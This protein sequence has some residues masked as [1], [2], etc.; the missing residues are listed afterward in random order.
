MLK[1]RNQSA[2]TGITVAGHNRITPSNTPRLTPVLRILQIMFIIFAVYG[3]LYGF[4]TGFNIPVYKGSLNLAIVLASIYFYSIL[5]F[6]SIIK[7]TLPVTVLFCLIAGKELYKEFLNGLYFIENI[8]IRAYNTYFETEILLYL[9]DDYN[10]KTV[11]TIFLIFVCI[12]LSFIV[13]LIILNNNIPALY[14]IVT[15][16]IFVLP[17]IVGLMPDA[18]PSIFY[19]VGCLCVIGLGTAM[20]KH[21]VITSKKRD[22]NLEKHFRYLIGFKIGSALGVL[23]LFLLGISTFLLSKE[24]YDTNYN[25]SRVK[26]VI[27]YEIMNLSIED[28]V[29]RLEYTRLSEIELFREYRDFSFGGLDGGNLGDNGEV[30]F[31]NQPVLSVKRSNAEGSVYLKGYVGS[32]YTGKRWE[33]LSKESEEEYKKIASEWEKKGFFAGNQSVYL[34]SLLEEASDLHSITVT[35]IRTNA[36]HAYAPYYTEFPQDGTMDIGHPLYVSPKDRKREY[37]FNYYKLK[38]ELHR[39]LEEDYD[40]EQLKEYIEYEK[41]YRDFIYKTY[42]ALPETGLERIKE[43]V[44]HIEYKE[45]EE[46]TLDALIAHVKDILWSNTSYSLSPGVLPQGED[47]IE[48]FLYENKIGYCAHYASAAVVMFR[49]MGVPARYVEGY[50]VKGPEKEV[51]VIDADAHAWAE[52]YVDGYGWV[53]VE[54]TP[55]YREE[56]LASGELLAGPVIPPDETEENSI[57][58][59]PKAEDAI[60]EPTIETAEPEEENASKFPEKDLKDKEGEESYNNVNSATSGKT[61]ETEA[62]PNY[63]GKAISILVKILL[64]GLGMVVLLFIRRLLIKYQIRQSIRTGNKNKRVLSFYKE[65]SR[66]LSFEGIDLSSWDSCEEAIEHVEKKSYMFYEGEFRKIMNISLKAKFSRMNASEEELDFMKK[67]YERVLENLYMGKKPVYQWYLKY[68][69]IFG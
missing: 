36:A 62:G 69:K 29:E 13:S 47:Y 17:L 32:T 38:K 42:T 49:A 48:Y 5:Q 24:S 45:T 23:L 2:Y 44:G 21:S 12:L 22:G 14:F 9:V 66:M 60:K 63:K 27:Q 43:Q 1:V 16:P 6:K 41:S 56:N 61:G 20:R 40:E 34:L 53:V 58:P 52:V 30:V 8:F 28:V 33:G 68:I 19:I 10:S 50:V 54:C 65:V 18:I 31:D 11:I 4:I 67:E 37:Q 15:L 39:L 3:T 59:T 7:Y 55:G 57:S 26:D 64:I 25:I 46:D 51:L 35:N